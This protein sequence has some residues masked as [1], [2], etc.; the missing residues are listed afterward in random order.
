[1]VV[2]LRALDGV[3]AD[4]LG[5]R[6]QEILGAQTAETRLCPAGDM[7]IANPPSL[8]MY[9]SV[10][11]SRLRVILAAVE[12]YLRGRSEVYEATQLPQG[13]Q[14]EH[15][16]PRRGRGRML[17]RPTG[18]REGGH[19]NTGRWSLFNRFSQCAEQE[20]PSAH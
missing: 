19:E 16:M 13:L 9:G 11:Q 3:P 2:I 8:R 4:C 6:I 14:I 1:M 10:K 15:I 5:E 18:L 12:R 20:D 17:Q 7:L